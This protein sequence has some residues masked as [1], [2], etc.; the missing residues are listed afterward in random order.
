MDTCRPV[1]SIFLNQ[2]ARLPCILKRPQ[3]SKFLFRRFL[4]YLGLLWAP[5]FPSYQLRLLFQ[6]TTLSPSK[7]PR[8]RQ[9]PWRDKPLPSPKR[10]RE[11]GIQNCF[12]V[13][14]TRG[15]IPPYQRGREIIWSKVEL[16][17]RRMSTESWKELTSLIPPPACLERTQPTG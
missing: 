17:S 3:T 1:T 7:H 13:E 4:S 10:L 14:V 12:L 2:N 6:V 11:P 5:K 15:K 16:V 8:P 9:A